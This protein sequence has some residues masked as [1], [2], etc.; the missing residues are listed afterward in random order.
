MLAHN[1]VVM[2][3]HSL[4]HCIRFPIA[5]FLHKYIYRLRHSSKNNQELDLKNSMLKGL[6]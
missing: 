3:L 2:N 4:H 5:E 1:N 6:Q